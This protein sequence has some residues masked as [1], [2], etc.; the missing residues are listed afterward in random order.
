VK[1]APAAVVEQAQA[2]HSELRARIEKLLQ[3][4]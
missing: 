3:N 1:N 4:Q 2:R